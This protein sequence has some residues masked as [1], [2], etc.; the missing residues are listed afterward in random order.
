[1]W[2]TP[3]IWVGGDVWIIGGGPSIPKLF[4]VPDSI[5]QDVFAG[6]LTPSAYSP[7]MKILH[8]RHVI[9]INVAYT[10]G[11]WIDMVFFGDNGFFLKHKDALYNF[12]GLK[13]S[14]SPQVV[15]YPWVKYLSRDSRRPFGITD[16][17]SMV[18]WNGNSGAAA[19]SVA[20]NAGAKRIFLLGFDM[21]LG[22]QNMQHWHDLYKRGH[23]SSTPTARKSL[24]FHRHLKGFA[25]IAKDARRRG[26]EI[27]NVNPESAI[28][29]LPKITL[30]HAL[31]M[32]N[33]PLVET[34]PIEVKKEEP[35][36]IE[37]KQEA[38]QVE[39][40][41]EVNKAPEP[42]KEPSR[43][44][45]I[46]TLYNEIKYLPDMVQ[47]WQN[48]GVEMY[49]IDNFSSDGTWQ[50]LQEHN[51]P[52]HRFSTRGAFDLNKL[53]REIEKTLH[54][55]QPDWFIYSSADLYF[56]FEEPMVTTIKRVALQGKNQISTH[57][58]NA[59]YTGEDREGKL[60]DTYFHC[61][62]RTAP[63]TMISKYDPSIKL[64]GDK[65]EIRNTNIH[66]EKGMMINFGDTKPPK[67][68]DETYKRRLK[69]WGSGLP[70]FYG[71]HYP[72]GHS[73]NWLWD[74]KDLT[75]LR[76]TNEFHYY[77]KIKYLLL[78]EDT[79]KKITILSQKD[80]AG[81]GWRIV[82]AMRLRFGH[83]YDIQAIVKDDKVSFGIPCGWSVEKWGVETAT[84]RI[85]E[86]DIIHFKGDW[87][88]T[89]EWEG[90]PLPSNVK[91]IYTVC[92][93]FFRRRKKGLIKN[94]SYEKYSL[95]EYHADFLSATT[96][97]LIYAKNWKHMP[98]AWLNFEYLW[99]RG[100]K[101]RVIHIPST[102][103]K[104]GSPMIAEAMKIICDRHPE[105]E[106]IEKS[107]I[108]YQ[109][110]FALKRTAHI[111]IDQ[112]IID[113][114]SNASVEAMSYGIPV[115]SSIDKS[116]YP[117]SCPVV[118]PKASV[119]SMIDTM[120]QI[121][122][123]NVLE[124][125][126]QRSFE[127]CKMM[128]GR[129]AEKWDEVYSALYKPKEYKNKV[130]VIIPT[131]NPDRKPFV[132]YLEKRLA[133]QT[134]QPDMIIK[135]DYP[136]P[137]GH[138][139]LAKRYREGCK[140]AFAQDMDLAIFIEDDDYYPLSYI[141]SMADAWEKAGRPAVIGHNNT[142]YYHLG[143]KGYKVWGPMLHSS[144]HCT[145]VS[146]NAKLDVCPDDHISFDISLWRANSNTVK[147]DIEPF[148]VSIK[149][150]IGMTA[151]RVHTTKRYQQN[152]D[153]QLEML[154]KWV[155]PES[156]VFY[157]SIMEMHG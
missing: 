116:L 146:Q 26:V 61:S 114:Y 19:I 76:L 98:F 43:I 7:Y 66:F 39:T 103:V 83:K 156:F 34:K 27:Y 144:A 107:G 36:V 99:K 15:K 57:C 133:K 22:D 96:P 48:Q 49:Y 28:V 154:Q 1:M 70:R 12:P 20:V 41:E 46:G 89:T 74:K 30:E 104:K 139:D 90:I 118:A 86:S 113:A 142:R 4:K 109:E 106:Y 29:D 125:L 78:G 82:Q 23:I 135:I 10:I 140:R 117:R 138:P 37:V 134:R 24:P 85:Q 121:L 136:N 101:I 55:L 155:D 42:I 52:S 80:Y 152:M 45:A 40:I 108:P 141:E 91:R 102:G 149:H 56:G 16:Q 105:V 33:Y 84:K 59:K 71:V 72:E 9:G 94:V 69:A 150:G 119:Q 124:V 35:M 25:D 120:E 53:Q 11:D 127:Y 44:L 67:S 73:K 13:V 64:T 63:L 129:M 38:I 145:A 65:I 147:V 87:P 95:N 153:P 5:I 81:S 3:K 68:R 31:L 137:N 17:S 92:G 32:T 126:S 110:M 132:D 93:S 88:Y 143:V 47:F 2:N 18:S 54:R 77:S 111:Y 112:L 123:W 21:K 157:K 75:D 128:H 51:I 115:V 14:C 151:G 50:W 148:P 122:N 130:A 58:W 62:K 100:D 60:F 97:D 79:R 131:C 6:K 8:N